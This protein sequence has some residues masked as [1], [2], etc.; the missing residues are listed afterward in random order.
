VTRLEEMLSLLGP[1]QRRVIELR[2][3]LRGEECSTERT[4]ELLET[5]AS[6]VTALER[7]ALCRLRE[8]TSPLELRL[9]A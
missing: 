5:S 3:G 6:K 9:A 4:A 2:F 1:Q 8:L 7:R